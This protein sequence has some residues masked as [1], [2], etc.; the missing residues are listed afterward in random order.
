M[1]E[2]CSVDNYVKDCGER[3]IKCVKEEGLLTLVQESAAAL[4]MER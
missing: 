2:P 1:S 4:K 3:L